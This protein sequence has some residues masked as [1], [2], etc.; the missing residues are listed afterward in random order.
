MYIS[1]YL[2]LR[3]EFWRISNKHI[4][5]KME[6][7]NGALNKS[8][9]DRFM[10]LDITSTGKVYT[11]TI[12]YLQYRVA[13]TCAYYL[14]YWVMSHMASSPLSKF[15]GKWKI[16]DISIK[17][18]S[19]IGNISNFSWAHDTAERASLPCAD[20]VSHVWILSF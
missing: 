14:F 8:V 10:A 4:V 11:H 12:H 13:H 3:R 5:P 19:V 16:T 20:C 9:L 7:H 2:H 6:V 17:I 1:D 15:L 18:L